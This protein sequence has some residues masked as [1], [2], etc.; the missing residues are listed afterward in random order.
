MKTKLPRSAQTNSN[1]EVGIRDLKNLMTKLASQTNSRDSWSRYL[2]ICMQAFNKRHVYNCEVS[3]ANLFLSPFFHNLMNYVFCPPEFLASGFN[4]D[5][6]KFQRLTYEQ[7]NKKRKRSLY[8]LHQKLTSPASFVLKAGQIVTDSTDKDQKETINGSKALIPG[9]LK[10][11]KVLRVHD[12]G[13]GAICK[14]LHTGQIKTVNVENMRSL[15]IPDI[16]NVSIDPKH[17]FSELLPLS[18]N[19]NL[20]GKYYSDN[21]DPVQPPDPEVR[22]T[23]SGRSY[24]SQCD[25]NS[26]LLKS[27]LKKCSPTITNLDLLDIQQLDAYK[28]GIENARQAGIRLEIIEL[29]ALLYKQV[30]NLQLYNVKNSIVK[31]RTSTKIQFNKWIEYK[32]GNLVEK[33]SLNEKSNLVNQKCININFAYHYANGDVS[34]QDT[35]CLSY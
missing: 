17:A 1:A 24:S 3:R 8:K 35:L 27:C 31:H 22:E 14:N 29:N 20:Y 34:F 19:L 32:S 6:I 2:G 21:E 7:L 10:L 9:S 18:R 25:Q 15:S 4:G 23:R 33:L 12:G 11:F 26:R 28:R 5:L 30:R 13:Q 16:I